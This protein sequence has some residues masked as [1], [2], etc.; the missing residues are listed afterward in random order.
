MRLRVMPGTHAEMF[1]EEANF[2]SPALAQNATQATSVIL[3]P[4]IHEKITYVPS[5]DY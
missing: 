1:G 3:T 5:P 2:K 4:C